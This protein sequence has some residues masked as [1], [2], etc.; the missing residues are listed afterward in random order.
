MTRATYLN[1]CVLRATNLK[2]ACSNLG[3]INTLLYVYKTKIINPIHD[4]KRRSGDHYTVGT[5]SSKSLQWPV[6][7][8][9]NSSDINVFSQIFITDEYGPL[10]DLE[11]VNLV[12]DCGANVG[13]SSAFFL[14]RFPSARVLSIEPDE[15]NYALLKQNLKPYGDRVTSIRSAIWSHKAK[16]KVYSGDVGEE[17][18]WATTVGECGEDEKADVEAVDIG[19]LLKETNRDQI[20]ILKIDIE[21][22][23]RIV[24]SQNFEGWISKVRAFAIELHNNECRDVFHRA[25]GSDS[26]FFRVS[27]DITIAQRR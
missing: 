27:G 24:F 16:L 10:A 22:A 5:L 25:L 18:E 7:F 11:D 6:S 12:I 2:K 4:W 20:D 9:Y 8:R 23:E 15:R 17:S 14:S 13:Y 1:M 26:F 21:G 3:F 19:S